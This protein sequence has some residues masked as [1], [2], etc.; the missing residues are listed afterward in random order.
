MRSIDENA[1]NQIVNQQTQ[2]APESDSFES[3]IMYEKITSRLL[4]EPAVETVYI[5]RRSKVTRVWTIVDDPLEDVYDS[6][7]EREASIV[8][9]FQG[10]HFDFSV[11]ARKGRETR[12]FMSF[13]CPGWT[14]I[15]LQA[16]A[17]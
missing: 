3:Q 15:D 14:R 1:V 12:S 8:R 4:S 5:D 6:I 13:R 17:R 2:W 7:Y 16:S 9:E 10:E 11:M